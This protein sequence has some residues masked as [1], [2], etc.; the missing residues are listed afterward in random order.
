MSL[1]PNLILLDE[2]LNGVKGSQICQD[3]RNIDPCHTLPIVL[4][5]AVFQLPAVAAKCR[6]DAFIAK[7]FDI[8]E[9]VRIVKSLIRTPFREINQ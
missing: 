1:K 9:L 7:P 5:S 8:D 4:I 6:A 3:L 2:W